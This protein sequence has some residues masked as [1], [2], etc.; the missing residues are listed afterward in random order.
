[1]RKELPLI[2][3]ALILYR[4]SNME[5]SAKSVDTKTPQ[6]MADSYNSDLK[7]LIT[8]TPDYDYLFA[9]AVPTLTPTPEVVNIEPF[10][11][12]S[13]LDYK[14]KFFYNSDGSTLREKGCG[15][16]VGA[17]VTKTDPD[18]YIQSFFDYFKSI[19]M[20]GP[21]HSNENGTDMK[22]HI[23]V[24]RSLGYTVEDL[25]VDSTIKQTKDKIAELTS[26]GIPVWIDA[27]LY[28]M[29]FGH[30]TMAIGV[31]PDDTI[32]FNDPQYGE[33]IE[34]EDK[35]I[36]ILTDSGKTDWKVFAVYPPIK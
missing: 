11:Y 13:Q 31:K 12:F 23:D 34:I 24:L 29:Q 9:T 17:M 18:T 4:C 33:N 27:K 19:G 2:I 26:Q 32:I 35:H 22:D 36:K 6:P 10:M 5:A 20:W 14:G 16:F 25:T 21:A 7:N 15:M 1:M 3:S 30:H 8:P 28:G